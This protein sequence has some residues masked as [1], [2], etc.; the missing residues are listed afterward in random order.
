MQDHNPNAETGG[1][2]PAFGQI[3]V[4]CV[5]RDNT[6]YAANRASLTL[7]DHNIR[8]ISKAPIEGCPR[9]RTG[10]TICTPRD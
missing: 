6:L 10:A 8:P 7:F 2:K 1:A 9:E 5:V 4:A 3:E